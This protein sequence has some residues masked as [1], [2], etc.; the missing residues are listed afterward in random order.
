MT[1]KSGFPEPMNFNYGKNALGEWSG[2]GRKEWSI[3]VGGKCK[4]GGERRKQ[5]NKQTR[6]PLR[7]LN[8]GNGERFREK[9]RTTISKHSMAHEHERRQEEEERRK[10]KNKGGLGFV[11][12]VD[13]FG[14]NKQ[15]RE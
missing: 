15:G 5:T 4:L 12:N 1:G 14:M 9:Q 8:R 10:K 11:A 13:N 7:E 3:K 2:N 6:V